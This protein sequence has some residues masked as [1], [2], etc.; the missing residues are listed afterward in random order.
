MAVLSIK[1]LSVSFRTPM[2]QVAAADRFSL[3]LEAGE[4]LALVGETG[5]GKSVVASSVMGLLPSNAKVSG[6]ILFQGIDLRR[7]E[8]R[9]MS[10]IRGREIAM[11]FQNPALSLD[12][13]YRIGDQVAEPLQV[14]TGISKRRS[15]EM[16][17]SAL[18]R[19]GLGNESMSYPFQLSGGMNQRAMVATAVVSSPKVII[20]DEPSK[21]LDAQMAK[22]VMDQLAGILEHSDS[23]LLLITHDLSIARRISDRMAIMY[24]GEIVEV[25]ETDEI[26]ADPVHPYTR[27]L[28]DCLP[29]RGFNPIPGASPSMTNPP[30]GCKFHPRCPEKSDICLQRPEMKVCMVGS[31]GDSL[32]I[33]PSQMQAS[34]GPRSNLGRLK[35]RQVRCWLC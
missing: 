19:M 16:A 26:F 25:G 12:P 5:C 32:K 17:R 27:A 2:G 3:D 24:C 20:A 30:Q 21:G 23:S 34:N 35:A 7:L 31:N 14:H 29:E 11:V 22:E 13:V 15:L 6:E 9:E 1:N 8:E 28:L 33:H 4:A 18:Q 10:H